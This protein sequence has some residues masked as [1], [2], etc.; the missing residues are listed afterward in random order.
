M[1]LSTNLKP[2]M[3]IEELDRP[4]LGTPYLLEGLLV[5][6]Q[7]DIEK[8]AQYSSHVFVTSE[9]SPNPER[10]AFRQKPNL[11]FTDDSNVITT[12]HG[13]YIYPQIKN[14]EQELVE[15]KKL[16]Q[17]AVILIKQIKEGINDN[18]KLDIK[19]AKELVNAVASSV[20]RNPDAM[21]LI[22]DMDDEHYERSITI[23]TYM[24][25]F[26]RYLCLSP[27]ELTLLGL[28]GLLMDIS[29]INN[30]DS[31]K[32]R[33]NTDLPIEKSVFFDHVQKSEEI[34]SKIAGMP[35][36]VLQIVAQHHEREDGSGY[37]RGIGANQIIPYAQMA[38]IVDSYE[39]LIFI[40]QNSTEL[41]MTPFE[42]LK[43]LRSITSR[44][45]NI[46]LVQQFV[47]CIGIF[48]VGSLIELNTGEVA[49]VLAHNR[50][51]HLLPRIMIILDP[52]KQ[53]YTKPWSIDLASSP[54]N[55]EA[56]PYEIS[57]ELARN[58]YGINPKDYYL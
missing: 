21:L 37:P 14:L 56:I 2:G 12:F 43:M 39:R 41:A 8:V 17:K 15:A 49:I 58:A 10:L 1:N 46:T 28:G 44:W 40:P 9:E 27:E 19:V 54:R 18:L 6:S 45:L 16:K 57:Y 11:M 24:I 26:G 5:T 55:I 23:A 22:N 47:N 52:N 38:N 7:E 53:P 36:I 50:V 48:P 51:N 34:L 31:S 13:H 32:Y 33:E 4:W 35:E 25:S 42:A 29:L 3:F 20:I 30:L